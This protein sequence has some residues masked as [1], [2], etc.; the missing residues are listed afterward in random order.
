MN[1]KFDELTKTLAQS[2]TRRN[3]LKK[4]CVGLTGMALAC[5]GLTNRAKADAGGC[6][7]LGARCKNDRDCCAGI[8]CLPTTEGA[9]W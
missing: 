7:G 5:F 9:K 4:F 2:V 8:M 3:A 1:S 6:K